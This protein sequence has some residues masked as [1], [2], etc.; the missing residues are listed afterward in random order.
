MLKPNKAERKAKRTVPPKKDHSNN[1]LYSP[2]NWRLEIKDGAKES[3]IQWRTRG[4]GVVPTA[5][6]ADND[7]SPA[8]TDTG[9]SKNNGKKLRKCLENI[10]KTSTE[11]E[12]SKLK[13]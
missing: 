3:N 5:C 12:T 8:T 13:S 4:K 9:E 2:I 1:S 6:L 7:G 10:Y 11:S